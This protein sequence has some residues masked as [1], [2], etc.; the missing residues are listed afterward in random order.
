VGPRTGLD[1]LGNRTF[2][3]LP[4]LELRPLCRVGCG[5]C[6]ELLTKTKAIVGFEVFT[7]VVMK[8]II[9]WDVTPCSLLRCKRRFGGTYRLHLQGRRKK[10]SKSSK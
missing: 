6:L 8:T 9:F 1:D 3:T 10:F 5:I 7:A 2:L 4:G